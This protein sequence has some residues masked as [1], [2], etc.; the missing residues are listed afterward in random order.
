MCHRLCAV[1]CPMYTVSS[2]GQ[3]NENVLLVWQHQLLFLSHPFCSGYRPW[4]LVHSTWNELN[5][6][7]R[8]HQALI[9]RAHSPA[10]K[11]HDL[12]RIDWLRTLQRNKSLS[13]E[14]VFPNR[15]VHTAVAVKVS[16]VHVLWTWFER[17]DT[18][19]I[20]MWTADS[21]FN[22]SVVSLAS[23]FVVLVLT[24]QKAFSASRMCTGTN[25][26]RPQR[27]VVRLKL[28]SHPVRDVV[29]AGRCIVF[30]AMCRTTEAPYRA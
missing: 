3:Q 9:G 19:E 7:R 30:V 2:S 10:R 11:R 28:C 8:T 1:D 21:R 26:T 29:R 22:A 5:W 13:S 15:T 20:M 14:H 6:T 23:Q 4:R 12:L 17:C 25:V 18:V 16:S 24:P 27:W